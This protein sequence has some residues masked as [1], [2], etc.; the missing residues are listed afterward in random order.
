[1]CILTLNT[2]EKELAAAKK[3][4]RDALKEQERAQKAQLAIQ[5]IQQA[6]NLITASSKISAQAGVFAPLLIAL[7]W[8]GFVASKVRAAQLTKKQFGKGGLEV[9]GG[10]SHASGNDTPL[11][12]NVGGKAAYAERGE[13]VAIIPTKQTRKYRA[14]LPDLVNSLRRGTFE[15]QYGQ[16]NGQASSDNE[17]IIVGGGGQ[18]SSTDITSLE[19]DVSEMR[20]QGEEKF[21]NDS[22]GNL[23]RRYKNTTRIYVK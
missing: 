7:L 3:V 15:E 19:S 16:M 13:A 6:S 12:F 22:N 20:K 23:V 21:H 18:S 11:G 5:S 14:I 9:L 10:G 2:K 8:S 4:Q 17:T 1:M